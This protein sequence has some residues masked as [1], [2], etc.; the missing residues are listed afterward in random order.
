MLDWSKDAGYLGNMAIELRP[1][2]EALIR[3]R[4]ESGAFPNAAE[5]IHDALA[6]QA[7]ET[8]WFGE[9]RSA[10]DGKIERGLAQLARGES[11]DGDAARERFEARKAEWR[12]GRPA[13]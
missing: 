8:A 4:I 3:E 5:V 2:D 11:I 1:E 12:A 13:R 7:A 9:N 6:V 10:I